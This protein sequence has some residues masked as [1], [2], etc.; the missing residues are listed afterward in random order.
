MINFWE[1]DEHQGLLRASE[2]Y[3]QFKEKVRQQSVH[4]Q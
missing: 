2:L 4:Y 3:E 1:T